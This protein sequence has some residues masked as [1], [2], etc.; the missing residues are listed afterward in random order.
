MDAY[1]GL[2][3]AAKERKEEREGGGEEELKTSLALT[4]ART[5]W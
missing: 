2:G 4:R 5:F 3:L 1:R